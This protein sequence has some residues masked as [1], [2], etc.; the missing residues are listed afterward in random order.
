[1]GDAARPGPTE[2]YI[3]SHTHWDREWYLTFHQFRVHLLDV[4]QG[5]LDALEQAPA[6]EHFC[7]DGQAIALEDYV[8]IRPGE[9]AR[10]RRLAEDGRLSLG[11]WYVLPDE[12]LVSA[13]ATVRNLLKKGI[14][15]N[16]N[17]EVVGEAKDAFE[18][19][20]LLLEKDPDVVT[21][22]IVMPKMDGIT[23]LKKIMVYNPKP[24]IIIST[25]AQE[26]SKMRERAKKIGAV[27]VIDKENLKIYQGLDRIR[28]IL[29]SKIETVAVLPVSK[30][31][32]AKVVDV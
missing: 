8:E 23:F 1:M 17:M 29:C 15:Q 21:L 11:P 26:N 12:F 32:S 18:A 10:I 5:V 20:S 4:V 30:K 24:V 3:V 14:E 28:N 19:R 27:S 6:F 16:P 9:A 31:K 13:E 22:D 7:L 2:A 25:I